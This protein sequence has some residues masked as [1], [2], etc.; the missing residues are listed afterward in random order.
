MQFDDY[1]QK[2]SKESSKN[3]LL[4]SIINDIQYDR[5]NLLSI[6]YNYTVPICSNYTQ[7]YLH[8]LNFNWP[9]VSDTYIKKLLTYMQTVH[10]I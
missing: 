8:L 4:G 9:M 2:L 6:N 1:I 3:Y 7:N 10:F 5:H